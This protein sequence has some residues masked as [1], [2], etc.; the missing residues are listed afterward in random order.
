MYKQLSSRVVFE[1]PRMTL[2][3]DEVLLPNGQI[4]IYLKRRERGHGVTVICRNEDGRLL[5]E[6]DYSY[7]PNTMLYQFPGGGIDL[8]EAPEEGANR[9]LTEEAGLRANRLTLLG[10]YYLDHRKSAE[11][12]YVYLAEELEPATCDTDDPYEG[13]IDLF[14]LTEDE[15]DAMIREGEIVNAPMLAAWAIYRAHRQPS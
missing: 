11:W 8:N 4:G 15:I 6:K 9:E 13:V 3:E 1:H 14:W 10:R 2:I 7:V 5:A 12:M